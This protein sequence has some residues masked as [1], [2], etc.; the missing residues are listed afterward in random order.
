MHPT[1]EQIDAGSELPFCRGIRKFEKK[2]SRKP[3]K[4]KEVTEIEIGI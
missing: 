1:H 3:Q 2:V 4:D